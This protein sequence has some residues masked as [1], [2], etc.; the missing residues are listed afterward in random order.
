MINQVI[1]V[2][3]EE[4]IKNKI[5]NTILI[6]VIDYHNLRARQI[7]LL[8]K[9]S[10]RLNITKPLIIKLIKFEFVEFLLRDRFIY[11]NF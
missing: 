9:I 7:M 1:I 8:I 2:I 11:D 3:N 6:S 4:Q 5:I 10:S